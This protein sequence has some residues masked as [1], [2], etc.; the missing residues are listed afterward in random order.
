MTS[1]KMRAAGEALARRQVRLAPPAGHDPNDRPNI[2]SAVWSASECINRIEEA[3]R[4]GSEG[5]SPSNLIAT[6]RDFYEYSS[7]YLKDARPFFIEV[8]RRVQQHRLPGIRTLK[9]AWDQVGCSDRWA[10]MIVAG[11][12]HLSNK[13][14]R[15]ETDS[16][17]Q[18]SGPVARKTRTD[19]DYADAIVRFA[20]RLLQP[21]MVRNRNRFD[22]ICID[23]EEF[24]RKGA[25]GD[26]EQ[27]KA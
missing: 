5:L 11:T 27:A 2:T 17:G 19:P 12:A 26:Y 8:K 25:E 4:I 1:S 14:K 24:F 7:H 10:R 15:T 16:P 23:L 3:V 6:C 18:G 21:L 20:I 22:Q 13:H 9:E